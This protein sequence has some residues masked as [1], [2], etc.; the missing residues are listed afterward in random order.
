MALPRGARLLLAVSGGVDSMV[1]LA[2]TA[3][4][5]R[6]LKLSLCVAHVDHGLRPSSAAE[7]E[8]VAARCQELDIPFDG[9]RLPVRPKGTNLEAWARE[10]RYEFFERMRLNRGAQ[11]IL[12]AHHAD[13][14]AE[15][16]LMQLM[17]NRP[18]SGISRLDQGRHLLRPLLDVR[19][20]D[21]VRYAMRHELEWCEDASNADPA[22][23]RNRVRLNL[24][25]YLETEFEPGIVG[26][27]TSVADRQAA[28][29]IYLQG[30]VCQ[31]IAPIRELPFGTRAWLRAVVCLLE[32]Q[33]LALTWRALEALFEPELGFRLGFRL[34]AALRLFLQGEG[35][36]PTLP[37]GRSVRRH[38][39]GIKVVRSLLAHTSKSLKGRVPKSEK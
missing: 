5:S 8:S 37:G 21:I 25:P 13:D 11:W 31:L 9:C 17:R 2:A 6:L 35:T 16:V 34:S 38:G 3:R 28:D 18:L 14:A 36:A 29:A 7:G 19:R 4:L 39:G 22:F 27:L 30:V 33:P 12:T 23:L 10:A 1:L 32:S 24:L 15:T 26:V 20:V